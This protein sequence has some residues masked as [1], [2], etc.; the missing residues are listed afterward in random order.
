MTSSY[1]VCCLGRK[2]SL[3]GDTDCLGL[4]SCTYRG[5]DSIGGE[6]SELGAGEKEIGMM[7]VICNVILKGVVPRILVDARDEKL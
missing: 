2:L 7:R 3:G 1:L 6:E 4:L 5:Y